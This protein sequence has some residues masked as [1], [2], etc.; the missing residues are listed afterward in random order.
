MSLLGSVGEDVLSEGFLE[1][2]E[3]RSEVYGDPDSDP[4]EETVQQEEPDSERELNRFDRQYADDPAFREWVSRRGGSPAVLNG[5]R[6]GESRHGADSVRLLGTQVPGKKLRSSTL[7]SADF[8]VPGYHRMDP[9]SVG[10]PA[11]GAR[12]VISSGQP[13]KEYR[14]TSMRS[15]VLKPARFDGRTGRV[16]SH[17]TQFAIIAQR[18]GWDDREKADHLMCS[19]TGEA[20]DLLRELA[21]DSS[22]DEVVACLRQHYASLDQ[23]E[24][25]RAQLKNRRRRPGEPLSEL[26]KDIR[27]LFLS[28]FPG[29]V[30]YMS[31]LAAKDAFISALGDRDLMVKVLE[32][33]PAT[34]NEAF[35][36]AERLELYQAIPEP[37]GRESKPGSAPRVR[38]T[39]ADNDKLVKSLLETQRDL[40]KQLSSL[41]ETVLQQSTRAAALRAVDGAPSG[42]SRI[43]CHHCQRPGHIRPNCPDRHLHSSTN[44]DSDSSGHG[45]PAQPSAIGPPPSRVQTIGTTLYLSVQIGKRRYKGLLDTGSEVTLLPAAFA[46]GY[47]LLPSYRTLRAANGTV[48]NVLGSVTQCEDRETRL[49]DR[50]HRVGPSG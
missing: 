41:H 27:R 45:H 10:V 31:D 35:K 49:V 32:R 17:L 39:V 9:E 38:G 6:G 36:V 7:R 37:G 50:I 30:N 4:D 33:E 21:A 2:C 28:A 11:R 14:V 42:K 46:E 34:L 24:I 26:M 3:I 15:N 25:Y 23:V 40:Q 29:P 16:E 18:N 1:R 22:Y 5:S 19:L 44:E 20:S 12:P 8:K 48:I 47:S 13:T 43:V